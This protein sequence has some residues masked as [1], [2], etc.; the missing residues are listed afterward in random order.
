MS[1][2]HVSALFVYPIKSCRGIALEAMQLGERGP[3]WDREWMVVD[4]QGTFL[5]Q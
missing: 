3:L 2:L 5:S 1:S 4:A